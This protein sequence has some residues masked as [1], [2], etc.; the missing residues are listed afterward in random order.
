MA[1]TEGKWGQVPRSAEAGVRPGMRDK[2]LAIDLSKETLVKRTNIGEQ[3]VRTVQTGYVKQ[4]HPHT[5]IHLCI[6]AGKRGRA[7]HSKTQTQHEWRRH[8]NIALFGVTS[9]LTLKDHLCTPAACV[10]V[11]AK[12]LCSLHRSYVWSASHDGSDGSFTPPA[13][14]QPA[15]LNNLFTHS[16]GRWKNS[17]RHICTHAASLMLC[18]ICQLHLAFAWQPVQCG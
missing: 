4:R 2:K 12:Q 14:N 3:G 16:A 1:F 10:Y 15:R 7:G 11:N 8:K 18:R 6:Q 9:I 13:P 5:L 17:I